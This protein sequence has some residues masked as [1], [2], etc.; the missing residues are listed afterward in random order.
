MTDCIVNRDCVICGQEGDYV[1][2]LVIRGRV[3]C[4]GCEKRLVGS[5]SGD[6][7]YHFYMNGLKKIWRCLPA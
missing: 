7:F 4:A 5:G 3:I 1:E 2:G 6:P